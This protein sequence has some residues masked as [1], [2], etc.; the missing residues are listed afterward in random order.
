[1]ALRLILERC[2]Q[3]ER[4]RGAQGSDAPGVDCNRLATHYL[5]RAVAALEMLDF[6]CKLCGD[7]D[8]PHAG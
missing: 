8:Q 5:A 1:M 7:L 6:T 2:R 4:S 3:F